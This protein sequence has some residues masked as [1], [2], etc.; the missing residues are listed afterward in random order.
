MNA[1]FFN[2]EA[3]HK[4]NQDNGSYN[5]STQISSVLYSAIIS[6]FINFIVE[7]LAFSHKDII[8]LRYYKNTK[9]ALIEKM[10][11]IKKLKIKFVLY[12]AMTIIFNALFFYYITAFCAVYSIIHAHMITDSLMSFFLTVSYSVV[13]SMISSI[14]RIYSLKRENKLRHVYY[15]ISWVVSLI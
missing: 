7:F 6:S 11:L 10:P 13:L 5:L 3:I 8:K 12:F 1:L 15:L 2:D 14:I 4:I 9:E